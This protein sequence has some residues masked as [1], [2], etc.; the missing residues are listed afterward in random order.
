MRVFACVCLRVC[1][2]VL[3]VRVCVRLCVCVC[4]RMCACVG[5]RWCARACVRVYECVRVHCVH[6]CIRTRVWCACVRACVS[7]CLSVVV[8]EVYTT[9]FIPQPHN[10][11]QKQRL[12]HT[13]RTKS[14]PQQKATSLNFPL[15]VKAALY[16]LCRRKTSG[17]NVRINGTVKTY[18]DI[19]LSAASATG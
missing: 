15:E 18:S 7:V 5:V 2:C 16:K 12:I 14:P 3:C 10:K 8:Y 17:E 11:V 9:Q 13:N 6:T 19:L 1:A 4:A